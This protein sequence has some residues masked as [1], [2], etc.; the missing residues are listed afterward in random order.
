MERITEKDIISI[1][2]HL[3]WHIADSGFSRI[4]DEIKTCLYCTETK[5]K[6]GIVDG[7]CPKHTRILGELNAIRIDGEKLDDLI[8]QEEKEAK[9]EAE[10]LKKQL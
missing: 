3:T 5:I 4:Y 7:T 2:L 10:E 1:L 6:L 8:D 9:Q